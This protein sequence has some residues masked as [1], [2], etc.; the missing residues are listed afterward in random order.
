MLNK[1]LLWKT[2]RSFNESTFKASMFAIKQFRIDLF[3]EFTL[4][5]KQFRIDLFLEFTLGKKIL[6]YKR[7][8]RQFPALLIH[9]IQKQ[10]IPYYIVCKKQYVKRV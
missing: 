8:H 5:K 4:G 6:F 7:S 3:L 10:I 2:S 9:L 1:M